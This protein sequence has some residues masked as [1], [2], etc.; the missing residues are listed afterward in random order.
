MLNKLAACCE[1]DANNFQ[2]IPMNFNKGTIVSLTHHL[3]QIR[4]LIICNIIIGSEIQ[5]ILHA[6]MST[7]LLTSICVQIHCVCSKIRNL[8]RHF[9]CAPAIQSEILFYQFCL[10]VRLSVWLSNAGIVSKRMDMSSHF[11][12]WQ[13]RHSTF[14]SLTAV[15]KFQGESFSG[16]D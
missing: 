2:R 3:C 11:L 4:K 16:G 13:G 1:N 9:Y 5:K 7:E 8:W 14:S 6:I 15:T 12:F 10:Y